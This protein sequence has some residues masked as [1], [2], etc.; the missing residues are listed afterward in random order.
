MCVFVCEQMCMRVGV[1][2]RACV[3]LRRHIQSQ[4]HSAEKFTP[5]IKVTKKARE[6]ERER[7]RENNI[8]TY[9]VL[10]FHELSSILSSNLSAQLIPE[11]TIPHSKVHHI[12]SVHNIE[13][14]KIKIC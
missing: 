8:K 14:V 6:R 5:K 1:C 9:L 13:Q 4:M 12:T 10:E 11:H 3:D 7:E 2:L